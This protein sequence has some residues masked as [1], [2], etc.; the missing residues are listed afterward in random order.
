MLQLFLSTGH[1]MFECYQCLKIYK[2]SKSLSKHLK[3]ECGKE[4][5]LRCPFCT[6]KC[7]RPDHLK[8]HTEKH[9]K[10]TKELTITALSSD[11]SVKP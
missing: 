11:K 3:Y 10:D 8:K 5:T 6:Y 2:H 7:K 4:A 9:H 1:L